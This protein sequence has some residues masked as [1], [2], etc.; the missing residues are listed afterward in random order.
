MMK[1]EKIKVRVKTDYLPEQS[2][3]A[4][5]RFVFAYH[6]TISN[7][8]NK[9]AQLLRRHWFITDGHQNVEEVQGDG[10]IGQQPLILPG[11]YYEYS[12]GTIM[13]TSVGSM[14]GYYEMVDATGNKFQALIPPFTLALPNQLH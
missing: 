7:C 13:K 10:V 1:N 4:N 9:S 14:H 11:E 6:I 5:N 2:S 8:G 12:S 3:L